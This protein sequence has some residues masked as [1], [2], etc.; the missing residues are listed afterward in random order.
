MTGPIGDEIFGDTDETGNKTGRESRPRGNQVCR[1]C[2]GHLLSRLGLCDDALE[3]A[4]G[5]NFEDGAELLLVDSEESRGRAVG[6][7]KGLQSLGYYC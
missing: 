4:F 5:S 3:D 7:K 6:P 1:R 2:C